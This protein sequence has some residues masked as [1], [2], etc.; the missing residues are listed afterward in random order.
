[1]FKLRHQIK[2]ALSYHQFYLD[3]LKKKKIIIEVH[4]MLSLGIDESLETYK[5]PISHWEEV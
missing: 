4:C 3:I 1:M 2:C 5:L